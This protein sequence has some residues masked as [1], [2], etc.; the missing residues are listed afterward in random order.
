[1]KTREITSATG[2]ISHLTT[3]I[4]RGIRDEVFIMKNE[5][6]FDDKIIDA[7]RKK[8]EDRHN[9]ALDDFNQ[10]QIIELWVNRESR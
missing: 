9:M 1:M 7:L 5:I 6:E 3:S 4:P 8:L 2:V 10:Y